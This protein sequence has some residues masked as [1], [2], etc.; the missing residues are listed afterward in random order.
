[1][2]TDW[3]RNITTR[4]GQVI[5]P[6]LSMRVD[7]YNTNDYFPATTS[8]IGPLLASDGSNTSF[9]SLPTAGINWRWPF[10]RQGKK[11][12]WLIEPM[13]QAIA[14]SSGG[15]PDEIPN[16]DSQSFEL[17]TSN[18][19]IP[20]KFPGLDQLESGNRLNVGIKLGAFFDESKS[21]T[22][23]FGQSL[24]SKS[25]REFTSSSGLEGKKSDYVGTIDLNLGKRLSIIHQFRLDED[26]LSPKKNEVTATGSY[27][28]FRVQSQ[29]I[30]SKDLNPNVGIM[31]RKELNISA[32]MKISKK[33]RVGLGT[34][35]DLI[36]KATRRAN[37]SI[38]YEDECT[39]FSIIFL[40]RNITDRDIRPDNSILFQFTLKHLN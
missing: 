3:E 8:G 6:F 9:R 22:V 5:T 4:L 15:N 13:V 24:R 25:E 7:L 23:L 17:D 38:T 20:N 32:S 33:W 12:R 34:R 27:G 26:S 28:R 40:K 10:I 16:E 30:S 39:L 35:Q 18:L 29:Y 19:F 31:S 37:A 2:T 36:A 1:V 21:V 14:S 11:V